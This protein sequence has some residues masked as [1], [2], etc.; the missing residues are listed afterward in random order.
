MP[1]FK[2]QRWFLMSR[3]ISATNHLRALNLRSWYTCVPGRAYAVSHGNTF[4]L[5]LTGKGIGIGISL[6]L[7]DNEEPGMSCSAGNIG[8]LT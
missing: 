8:V 3:E 5:L 6:P 1:Q 7:Q 4:P 2:K